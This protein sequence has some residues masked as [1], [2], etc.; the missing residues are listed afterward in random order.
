MSASRPGNVRGS[1]RMSNGRPRGDYRAPR[2]PHGS[3]GGDGRSRRS[4]QGVGLASGPGGGKLG[5]DDEDYE[6]FRYLGEGRSGG[7]AGQE[8]AP[9]PASLEPRPGPTRE[10]DGRPYGTASS[11]RPAPTPYDRVAP[12]PYDRPAPT[13]YDRP[14]PTPYDRP[15]PTPYDRPAPTPY[16]R[17]EPA[18][19]DRAASAPYDRAEPARSDAAQPGRT[20]QRPDPSYQPDQSGWYDG[21][22]DYSP[23][24]YDSPSGA[25]QAR[26]GRD[27]YAQPLYPM[28][29]AD[30][31]APSRPA[32]EDITTVGGQ[33]AVD[34]PDRPTRRGRRQK[35]ASRPG[36]VSDDW[37]DPTASGSLP[38]ARPAVTTPGRAVGPRGSGS[39]RT[40]ALSGRAIPPPVLPPS[41]P[42]PLDRS[43]PSGPARSSGAARP[44]ARFSRA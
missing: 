42:V 36:G 37:V 43:V 16:D 34:L 25:G 19:F 17:V 15:A 35:G 11:D 13:P 18:R 29:P 8:P 6:W 22:P 5:G 41:Y 12:T 1:R 4:G 38:T 2:S 7:L 31:V 27:D 20:R 30:D 14:K 28:Y 40:S 10:S 3:R 23:R 9:P 26:S 44:S 33:G 24:A 39:G 21:L 32:P